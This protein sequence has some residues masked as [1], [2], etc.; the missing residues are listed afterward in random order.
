MTPDEYNRMRLASG[1]IKPRHIT[2]L[3]RVYQ[4]HR[5]LTKDGMCGPRTCL[6]LDRQ[7]LPQP[8]HG[9]TAEWLRVAREEI[10]HGE[11]GGNNQGPDVERY[12]F[13]RDSGAWC[14]WF[15][16]WCLHEACGRLGVD[17]PLRM[18]G[19]AK[20]FFHRVERVGVA[21]AEPR[22]GAVACWDRGAQGS[23][24][25]HVELVSLVHGDGSFSSIGGNRGSYP[26]KVREYIHERG[27]GRLIGFAAL[28]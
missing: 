26:S 6:L 4:E 8:P 7:D 21:L 12:R 16:C 1:K 28:C 18:T 13:G 9:L 17:L 14:A 11:E 2:S 3:T 27:E 23:W 15:L 24:Q 20:R 25:G 22:L 10:G 5:G 19:G